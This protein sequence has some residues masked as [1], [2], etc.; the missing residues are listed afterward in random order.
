[1]RGLAGWVCMCVFDE[2]GNL[3]CGLSIVKIRVVLSSKVSDG[4][5]KEQIDI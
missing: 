3:V 1:M 2:N 4:G 5:L